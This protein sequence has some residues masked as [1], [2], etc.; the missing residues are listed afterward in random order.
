MQSATELIQEANDLRSLAD[1]IQDEAYQPE[2]REAALQ[3]LHEQ[4]HNWYRAAIR[5]FN[6]YGQVDDRQ[7]FEQEYH[8]SA[9]AVKIIKFLSSG[10]QI[11]PFYQPDTPNPLINKWAFPFVTCFKE[12]LLKQCNLLSL[13]ESSRSTKLGESNAWHQTYRRIVKEFVQRSN[14]LMDTTSTAKRGLTYEH[15]AL[16]LICA[17]DGLSL[18][19]QDIRSAA[20]ETDL[21][22]S[23]ESNDV[24]WN[25]M[26]D[27]ILIECKNWDKP[28]GASEIAVIDTK[29][30]RKRARTGI[31]LSKEGITG[32]KNRDAV[33]L[34]RENMSKYGRYLIVINEKDLI[35]IVDGTHPADKLKQKYYAIL[36]I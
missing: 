31:L 18:I 35:D 30:D 21:L 33:L 26:G 6:E 1:K 36:K 23:N 32:D 4:Y 29:M 15:L 20:E 16:V 9:F 27:P 3:Q 19:G 17:V 25:R 28:V 13:I 5:L 24:F 8:G 2:E 34:I 14:E 10:L 7:K 11:S 12:P 22:I